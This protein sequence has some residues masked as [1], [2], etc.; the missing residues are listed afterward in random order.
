MKQRRY[1]PIKTEQVAYWFFRLNGCLNIVN[2]L[3]HHER[4]GREGTE[5]D[6]LAVRFPHRREL[7]MS[8]EPMRDHPIFDSDGQIDVIISE[9]KT[10]RCDL[11]GPWTDP[12]K[13]NMH[14]VLY[15]VGAFPEDQVPCIADSLYEQQFYNGVQFRVRLFAL[16]QR[17]NPQLPQQV[18]QLTWEQILTF[19]Y[20]RLRRY[21]S[22][23]AQHRQWDRHGILLYSKMRRHRAVEGFV[24]DVLARMEG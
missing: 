17:T 16:G 11:N 10:G 7:A 6:I 2:F 24:Q 4:R 13:Q 15:A 1:P 9:V 18:V 21:W 19:I 8:G 20:E 12:D 3:V 14:R 5:V 23:K 22:I